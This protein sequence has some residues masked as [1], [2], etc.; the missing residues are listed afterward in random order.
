MKELNI[1][2]GLLL[3]RSA[4]SLVGVC[5]HVG[6][7][8]GLDRSSLVR[9]LVASLANQNDES[10]PEVLPPL[11]SGRRNKPQSTSKRP[12][13]GIFSLLETRDVLMKNQF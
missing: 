10:S 13:F 9:V 8:C 4:G 7:E 12:H 5:K 2:F 6:N 3:K 11:L 1:I